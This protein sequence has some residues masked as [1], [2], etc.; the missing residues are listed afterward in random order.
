MLRVHVHHVNRLCAKEGVRTGLHAAM[1]CTIAVLYWKRSRAAAYRLI[2]GLP[3]AE[4]RYA[5]GLAVSQQ[6]LVHVPRLPC[7]QAFYP[8]P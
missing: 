6:L 2:A 5:V 8:V 1:G 3:W 4:R 7:V